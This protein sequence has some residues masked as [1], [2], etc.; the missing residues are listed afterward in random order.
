[1]RETEQIVNI[2][3]TVLVLNTLPC[4]IYTNT[5]QVH[6]EQLLISPHQFERD[7]EMV[8]EVEVVDHVNDV[9]HSITVLH[10]RHTLS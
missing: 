6:R 2:V 8:P 3:F 10:V 4:V 7:T 5:R 1:M 9:V